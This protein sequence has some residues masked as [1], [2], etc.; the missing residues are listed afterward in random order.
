[1]GWPWNGPRD[2]KPTTSTSLHEVPERQ[3]RAWMGIARAKG[4]GIY[5]PQGWGRHFTIANMSAELARR[6]DERS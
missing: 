6:R 4:G 1:M 3:L 5:Q 2:K